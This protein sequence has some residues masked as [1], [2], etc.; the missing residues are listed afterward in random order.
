M[1]TEARVGAFTLTALALFAF[2]VVELTGLNW[3][4]GSNYPLNVTFNNVTGLR[5]GNLVKY[6]GVDIGRV[7]KITA[8][9]NG[10][11][12]HLTI[13]QN[14]S[15]PRNALITIG[16]DG[17]MG[18]K[19]ISVLL[20]QEGE[21]AEI[22][23]PNDTIAGV[24]QQGIEQLVA[25]A[26]LVLQDIHILVKSM[27]NMFGDEK[28]QSSVIE[29]AENIREMTANMNQLTAVMSRLAVN[30]E[31][32][33]RTMIA[34][35]RQISENM[36]RTTARI[37]SMLMQIDNNGQTARDLCEALA[38]INSTSRRIENM[39]A[40]LEGVVTDPQTADDLKVTLSNVRNVSEKANNML[41]SVSAVKIESGVDVMYSGGVDE[42]KVNT[43]TKI[44]FGDNKYM[45]MGINDLGEEN[46]KNLQF[47]MWDGKFGGRAGLIDDKAGLGIDKA[48]SDSFNMS[49]DAYDPNDFKLKLRAA[50]EIAPKTYI[51]GEADNINSS[52]ER[53]TFLGLRK[54]F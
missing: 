42:Y 18:E 39:A 5:S 33:V 21:A 50:Y 47:G 29:S 43:D 52:R 35:F 19:F 34:D 4:A 24:E 3:A 30:S 54:T 32:D 26:N 49:L 51:I 37:D 17:I 41:N 6:A 31:S 38:N 44:K 13:E 11:I 2:I 36:S 45:L 46:Y 22:L 14:S 7:E 8:E 28:F 12:V 15:I 23:Q 1:S 9:R 27:N 20:P 25:A 10:A 53:E 16:A 40:S 48:W